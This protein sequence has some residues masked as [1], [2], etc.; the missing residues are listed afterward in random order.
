MKKL[1]LYLKVLIPFF[2][3]FNLFFSS[4]AYSQETIPDPESY[5]GFIPGSDRMLFDYE[6]L[7]SYLEKLEQNSPKI[8]MEK[9]GESPMGKPMYAVFISSEK[10]INNLDKLKEINKELALNYHL[11]E[12]QQNTFVK[13]GKVFFLFTLSMHSN[14]VGPSQALPLIAYELLTSQDEKIN[15]WLNDVVYMVVPNHNPD[16]MDM[17]I[18]HYKKYKGTKYEGS[19]MPGLYHKYVGHDNNRD[20]VALT[21]SDTR[22]ISD[23]FSKEWFP[24]VM[25]EKHQMGS[26]GPRYFVSPPHDPIAENIDAG[27]WNWMKIFGSRTITKMTEAGLKG[28]SQNYLF[29]DYW[30]GP[31]ETCIWK[32]TI[33]M[34]TE[35]AS[36]K[37]ATPIY[38]EPNELGAYG[39][40]MGEYKKSINMPEPWEGGWWRLSDLIQYEII[41]TKSYLETASLYK[42]EILKFR[43]DM[44]KKE[45]SK[46]ENTP[47]YYYVFPQKQHDLSELVNL[48]NLLNDHGIKVYKLKKDIQIENTSF[49]SGD[50]IVP[51][52]QPFRAFIKEI[53]ES[54][55]FPARHYTPGGE[56]IKPYDITSWS[57]PLH[58]GVQVFEINENKGSFE[59]AYTELEA[60]YNLYTSADSEYNFL[61]L[62]SSNNNSFKAVFTALKNGIK[63]EQILEPYNVNGQE[64]PTGSFIVYKNKNIEELTK[65]LNFT[66]EYLKTNVTVT[67]RDLKLPRIALLETYYHAMD[68]G[69]TRYVLDSYNI[70]FNTIRPDEVQKID[71]EK[72][73]DVLIVPDEK[74]SVLLT[75][76][77][78]S[79]NEQYFMKYPP[80]YLRGMEEEG[81]E[82]ILKFIGNGG[83]A[84]AWRDATELFSGIQKISNDDKTKEEFEFPVKNVSENIVK[85][86]FSCPG[87]LLK[88][89]LKK[90]HPITYG[91]PS[92]VGVFHRDGPIFKTWQPYFDVDRRVIGTFPERDI[93]ISG[94]IENEEKIGNMT[95]I[96]WLKKGKGQVVLFSFNPQ[97]RASTPATYKL[98]FNSILL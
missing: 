74:K 24:Q 70:P 72:D 30:P 90:D 62:S 31:T 84:I 98:L 48:I 64:Y 10:N 1:K 35:G 8:K 86:G 5:F 15:S 95:S 27:I 92:S 54:Q 2:L 65:V 78:Q 23:L 67:K 77:F 89:N 26:G 96:V 73:Y 38:I 17:V 61:L 32:N 20:F 50:I 43:N 19:S 94:Y 83:K 56:L 40:G 53:L 97:F 93:L 46:G 37:Y 85:Q 41:S 76:S 58:K 22:A 63:V 44:C 33:G 68:A 82:K 59:N 79:E 80:E 45:V 36:A 87:S 18:N 51:L 11:S 69:W 4:V 75:G 49:Y 88:I 55:V 21:Q 25:V 34:L 13:E 9:I 52:A 81:Y 6:N 14:E 39:K 42:E 3:F 60:P 28:I 57:L 66:P 47:P 7:I 29:D 91:M 16:G 12:E 71:F